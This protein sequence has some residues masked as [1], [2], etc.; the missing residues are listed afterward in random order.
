MSGYPASKFKG[1]R[2]TLPIDYRV[3]VADADL[4]ITGT[5]RWTGKAVLARVG[6]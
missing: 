4:G 1:A 2:V 3:S 6:A 5:L